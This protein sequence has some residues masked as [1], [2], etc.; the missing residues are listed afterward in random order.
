M[1][2]VQVAP[3]LT[4]FVDAEL[5]VVALLTDMVDEGHIDIEAPSNVQDILPFIRVERIGGV[6]TQLSDS[7]RI[8]VDVFGAKG[9]R[10]PTKALALNVDA[11]L[12]SFPHVIAGVGVID[13]VDTDIS[14]N[15]VPWNNDAVILFTASY[16]ISVR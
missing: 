13:R 15:Q 8:A 11:R 7:S 6:S 12:R 2:R 14:P 1:T 9:N 16:K 3:E 4:P 5:A 10:T